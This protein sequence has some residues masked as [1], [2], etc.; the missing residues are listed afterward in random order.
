MFITNTNICWSS[1]QHIDLHINPY[2]LHGIK[3]HP[4]FV[5]QLVFI[6]V[7]E[8]NVRDIHINLNYKLNISIKI[9]PIYLILKYIF[10]SNTLQSI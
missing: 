2:P 3:T 5:K 4:L 9:K 1:S 7:I 10:I 6:I 8:C